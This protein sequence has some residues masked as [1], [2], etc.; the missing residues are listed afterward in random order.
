VRTFVS[1]GAALLIGAA[2]AHA[3]GTAQ[4]N[5]A[6]VD[7]ALN[8]G[9]SARLTVTGPDSVSVQTGVDGRATVTVRPGRYAVSVRAIGYRATA[10]EVM[11]DASGAA[12]RVALQPVALPLDAMVVTAARREQRLQDTPI[13]TELITARDIALSGASDLASVLVEQTGIELQGGMPSG[14]GVMLQGIG[15]ER[16]LV[17]VDG[18]PLAG[19][20]SGVLDVARIPTSIV[21]RVEVV[22][23]PQSTLYGS[24]AMGGVVN[25]VT[26]R[27]AGLG[28]APRASMRAG[29]QRR[30]EANGG[31]D[32]GIGAMALSADVGRR[33]VE[34]TPG[35]SALA[36]AMTARLD[37]AATA[38][39]TIGPERAVS[40]TVLATDERQRWLSG[41]LYQ[42][43]DNRQL[44][45]RVAGELRIGSTRL[46]PTAGFASLDHVLRASTRPQPVTGD[47]GQR[48]VQ[49]VALAG[50][51]T[52]TPFGRHRLD[53]GIET[54]HESIRAARVIGTTRSSWS[55]EPFTQLELAL[56][57]R[58][59]LVPGTR[60]S[61][62]GQWGTNI[63]PR[64]AVRAG[65]TPSVTARL[66]AGTGYRAPDFKELYLSFQNE[67]AQY[68]V[69]GN[70]DLR[71]EHSRNV[72]AGLEWARDRIYVRTQVFHNDL[73]DFIETRVISAPGAPLVFRYDNVAAGS[74]SG[75]DNDIGVVWPRVRLE[76][77][78]AFLRTRDGQ[79]GDE[80]LGRPTHSA[81]LTS[82]LSSRL[83][84]LSVTQLF[85]GRTPMTRDE[86]TGDVTSHRDGF[87]RTDA[88]LAL[89]ER[90]GAEPAFGVDNVFNRQPAMWA[91][92]TPRHFYITLSWSASRPS[93]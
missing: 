20:I 51:T 18:Q 42:I 6:V 29:S 32:F 34:T 27:P 54:K 92:P 72:T 84:R 16:V 93:R 63:S 3:Q 48:Q 26:R 69:E 40:A 49:N 76:G 28:F 89:A 33:S 80:L 81:R 35:R 61:W 47:T 12:I 74:T 57:D 19:R 56:G 21:E 73:H 9:V 87:M 23:G 41:S 77:G 4:L 78:Y 44:V 38:R 7:E 67:S 2:N 10:N 62:N 59:T 22:K 71:P 70:R 85:T 24:E 1:L 36:G 46:Q 30:L 58:V 82:T 83:A 11:V 52:S 13:T 90:W 15:S 8:Q 60:L 88:R 79:T 86:A 5:V 66:S 39:W 25:V 55:A 75:A 64:L 37:G 17:L 14:A 53:A 65:L 68:A 91:A 43:A 50:I 45:S 31:V